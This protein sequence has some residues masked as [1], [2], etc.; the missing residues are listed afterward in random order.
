[1]GRLKTFVRELQQKT[2]FPHG[3]VCDKIK[4]YFFFN[5]KRNIYCLKKCY[6]NWLRTAYD[7]VFEQIVVA[8]HVSISDNF[9]FFFN[10]KNLLLSAAWVAEIEFS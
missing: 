6:G 2:A 3:R 4:S 5:T 10:Y 8:T 1:M 7:D 9:K